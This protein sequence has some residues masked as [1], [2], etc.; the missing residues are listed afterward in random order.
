MPPIR[1]PSSPKTPSKPATPKTTPRAGGVQTW[2]IGG[3]KMNVWG[4]P[5]RGSSDLIRNSTPAIYFT[6]GLK[7]RQRMTV[8]TPDGDIQ[9]VGIKKGSFP[10]QPARPAPPPP[11]GGIA[12]PPAPPRQVGGKPTPKAD[13]NFFNVKGGFSTYAFPENTLRDYLSEGPDSYRA[14]VGEQMTIAEWKANGYPGGKSA[15]TPGQIETRDLV[16]KKEQAAEAKEQRDREEYEIR[17][18]MLESMTPEDRQRYRESESELN[19]IEN[20]RLKN[21]PFGFI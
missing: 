9:L 1:R 10:K 6:D 11:T 4:E 2:T 20:R 18:E 16:R 15:L 14:V 12:R 7:P 8:S 21:Y 13:A 5:A 3:K 17:Q 19:A